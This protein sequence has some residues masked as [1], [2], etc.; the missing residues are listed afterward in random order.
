MTSE[1]YTYCHGREVQSFHWNQLQITL[2][3]MMLH[4]IKDGYTA[5]KEGYTAITEDLKH[6]VHAVAQF[7]CAAIQHVR[8]QGITVNTI[9]QWTDGCA[10]QYKGRHGFA[11]INQAEME[12][13][14]TSHRKGPCDGLGEL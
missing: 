9:H 2:H 12:H 4:Y 13:N 5:I 1:N 8:D 11:E 3:P 10:A 6:D 7:E 14:E